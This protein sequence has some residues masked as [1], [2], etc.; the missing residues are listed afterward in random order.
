[1]PDGS[2]KQ[3]HALSPMGLVTLVM[4][5]LGWSSIPLFLKYFSS[6]MDAWAANGWRYGFSAL[7]W[8]PVLV[9]GFLRG[10]LPV[11]LWRAAIVPSIF[12]VTGQAAFAW[13]PYF[14]DPGLMTFGLRTQI[15]F[16]AVGAYLLFPNE[17]RVLR[18]PAF[19]GAMAVVFAGAMGTLLLARGH[20]DAAHAAAAATPDLF[21]HHLTPLQATAFGVVL[22]VGSGALFAGYALAVRHYMHGMHPVTAFAAICQF[23]GLGLVA[24]MLPMSHGAGAYVIHLPGDK[25]G[26]LALSAIIGIALGHVFYYTSI[27][28]L[29]VAVSSG[30]IQL[31]PI[32]VAVASYFIFHEVLSAVQWM[33]GV[34]AVGAAMVMLAVQHRLGSAD[35][36]APS[37]DAGE[38]EL[39]TSVSEAR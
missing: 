17:R 19:L 29:G 26:L 22:S 30:V 14:I 8:L 37:L 34:A 38:G 3:M 13:A 1:M 18:S 5:L 24:L 31:Q 2:T 16:V 4:T 20:A 10:T 32:I 21:G 28:R 36:E 11:N 7:L 27:A 12:N 6:D 23:T 9:A 39:E 35:A 25:L 15:I 33:C